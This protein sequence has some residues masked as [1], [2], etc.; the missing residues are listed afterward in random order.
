[1]R[2]TKYLKHL[3]VAGQKGLSQTLWGK[4]GHWRGKNSTQRSLTRSSALLS[5][6]TEARCRGERGQQ[7]CHSLER[8]REHIL[9]EGKF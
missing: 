1:M 7:S 5:Y 8:G 3:D 6:F 2:H 9:V 4:D